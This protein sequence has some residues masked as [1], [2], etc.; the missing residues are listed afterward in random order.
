MAALLVGLSITAIMMTA[1][2][3][4]WNQMARREKETE[5]VF[6][7]EQYAR[8]IGL[9]QRK[10]G[11]GALPPNINLLVDQRFLRKKYKDPIADDDFVHILLTVAPQ[12]GA[13][14]PPAAA[15]GGANTGLRGSA[16]SATPGVGAPGAAFGG[17]TGVTSKSKEQSIRLYKGRNHYNEWQLVFT[18][19]AQTPTAGGAGGQRGRQGQGPQGPGNPQ[20]PFPPGGGPGRNPGGRNPFPGP[21]N[22]NAPGSPFGPG[23]GPVFT[24][25]QPP[26]TGR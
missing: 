14:Q 17:I 23:R 22:P 9:F 15:R 21:G 4:V 18:P 20:G 2:M 26:P 24:P 16:F 19:P 7:G 11:P 6:R 3:P 10:S 8:A 5:L 12:Q 13:G 1:A 25:G